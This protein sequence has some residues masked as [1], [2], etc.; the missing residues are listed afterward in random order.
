[1]LLTALLALALLCWQV[2]GCDEA[3]AAPAPLLRE[4]RGGMPDSLVGEWIVE[5]GGSEYLTRLSADGSYTCHHTTCTS[6]VYDGV[7]TL[8]GRTLWVSECAL[9]GYYS[10]WQVRLDSNMRGTSNHHIKI[11]LRRPR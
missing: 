5:W 8:R 9:G 4:C 10:H 1:M 7:W 3:G 6:N 11:R 2:V